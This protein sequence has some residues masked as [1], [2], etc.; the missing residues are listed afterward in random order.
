MLL[1]TEQRC[2]LAFTSRMASAKPIASSSGERRMKKAS[3]CALLLPTP[4]S[5]FSSSMRRAIGSANFAM[6][7]GSEQP[8]QA[9]EHA[10]ESGLHSLVHLRRGGVHGGSHQVL[11]H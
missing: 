3:R 7:S 4:G 2:R 11:Q 1:H 10:A 9:A 8:A 5:F 6:I